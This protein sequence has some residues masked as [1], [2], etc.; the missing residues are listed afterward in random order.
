MMFV[1]QLVK[2]FSSRQHF[3]LSHLVWEE[4]PSSETFDRAAALANPCFLLGTTILIYIILFFTS[5]NFLEYDYSIHSSTLTCIRWCNMAPVLSLFL[6]HLIKSCHSPL[7]SVTLSGK[8]QSNNTRTYN[9]LNYKALKKTCESVTLRF[10]QENI[11]CTY[12]LT[13][14]G[15]HLPE[16]RLTI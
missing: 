4:K 13:E 1:L 3:F 6:R 7:Q 5:L 8:V 16:T 15:I 10:T 2:R 11:I 12:V 9:K 14:D